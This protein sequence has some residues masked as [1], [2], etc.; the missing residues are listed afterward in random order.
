VVFKENGVAKDAFKSSAKPSGNNIRLR[1]DT[2]P[3]SSN[4]TAG[5]KTLLT[6][7]YQSMDLED[8]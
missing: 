8:D 4:Y 3:Y 1:I 5:L 6:F 2:T 7:G